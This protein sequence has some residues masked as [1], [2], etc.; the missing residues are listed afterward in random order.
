MLSNSEVDGTTLTYD[1][2]AEDFDDMVAMQYSILYDE[3]ALTNVR[4]KNLSLPY[5]TAAGFNI[6]QPGKVLNLWLDPTLDGVSVADGDLLYQI[7][8][9]L[10]ATEPGDVCFAEDPVDIEFV[11]VNIELNSFI[12]TDDCHPEPF[13]ILQTASNQEVL[14]SAG[15]QISN[16]VR[17]GHLSFTAASSTS[18]TFGL[19]DQSGRSVIDWPETTYFSGQNQ[20]ALNTALPAGMYILAVSMDGAVASV[21]IIVVE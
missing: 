13:D 17:N 20:I 6:N 16:V 9:E 21:P 19:Y 15:L 10:I 8:F 3:T 18:I 12:V 4:L 14:E 11:N 7:E 5:L 2:R 1:V